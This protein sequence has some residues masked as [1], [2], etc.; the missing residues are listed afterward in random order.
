MQ[1]RTK[2][3]RRT[4]PKAKKPAP[5][6]GKGLALAALHAAYAEGL[7]VGVLL[8]RLYDAI[9]AAND[10]G[11]FLHLRKKKELLA[12]AD[13][14]PA[15][16][17][18]AYPLWGVPFAV[19]D[20]I[21]VAGMPTTCAC[22]AFAYEPAVSAAAVEKLLAAGAL[23]IGKTNLDQFATGLVGVRT[24]YPAP[25][26]SVDAS[27]VPGGSSSGSAVAVAR[28]L[29]SFALGTDTAGSGRVPAA[30][31]N[32]VGLKPSVGAVSS[33]GVI[34][35]CSTL[36]CVSVLAGTVD[37]AWRVFEVMAG[38][39]E[40]D[41]FSRR[42][43]AGAL[44]APPPH[45]RIAIPNAEGRNFFGDNAAKDAF[46]AALAVLE[47]MGACLVEIDMQPFFE[48]AAMLYG[49]PWVAER[50]AALR[51]FVSRHADEIFP[52][53]RRIIESAENYSAADA[54]EAIYRL[55]E[56][57]RKTEAV[58]NGITT[59]AVPSIPRA[60]S[61]AEVEADPIGPNAMLGTFTNFVN[62]LDLAALSVPGRWQTNGRPAAITFIGPRGSD[63]RLASIGRVFQSACNGTIG[64]T[65]EP[66]PKL[67]PL[68]PHA[69]DNMIQLAVV[70]AHLSGMPLNYQIEKAGGIFLRSVKTEP[71][72]RLYALLSGPIPKPAL[73][74]VGASGVSIE[75]EVWALPS[76]EFGRF[77]S[78]IPP[79]LGIGTVFLSDGTAPKGFIG[80]AVAAAE[81]QDISSFG[82]WRA[83]CAL[84]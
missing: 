38:Y 41:P 47:G 22:P 5:C 30:L 50:L 39:D 32:I 66:L 28:G 25:L 76:E 77:V 83:Y 19:K 16:D 65:G 70:G 72:Y 46:E 61:L 8:D 7:P 3:D 57:R 69:P 79:P 54:F 1:Q 26:N 43:A 49:G 20:N 82:G 42:I 53:T 6:A 52:V 2:R 36:D 78:E 81:G 60:V 11:I 33:R 34:P 75:T 29:V 35:A 37:D 51:P 18:A 62:L 4:P 13:A 56:L 15:F 68:K 74:R 31:N 55:A 23:C 40:A 21:D 10:P 44:S 45:P 84:R 12:A 48:T 64:A 63:G 24:P 58:W 67:T 17:P 71:I 73:I 59:L 14:L 80:E 27:L 9:A